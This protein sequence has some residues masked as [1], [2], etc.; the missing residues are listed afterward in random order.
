MK[1]AIVSLF[2]LTLPTLVSAQ[3]MEAESSVGPRYQYWT[4]LSFNLANDSVEDA[5]P[6]ENE[7]LPPVPD[8]EGELIYEVNYQVD[9]Y[10]ENL[11]WVRDYGV[12]DITFDSPEQVTI[13]TAHDTQ[14]CQSYLFDNVAGDVVSTD[15]TTGDNLV[16]EFEV[17]RN[18]QAA[19]GDPTGYLYM[20]HLSYWE[21]NRLWAGERRSARML[22]PGGGDFAPVDE[23]SF[24]H[25]RLQKSG[26]VT[27]IYV[28]GVEMARGEYTIYN[29]TPEFMFRLEQSS[30]TLRNFVFKAF[31][32]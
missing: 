1:S 17:R 24:D 9:K 6:E 12:C 28:N 26:N 2:F 25:Y 4:G 13:S 31:R 3:S 8:P 11:S 23:Y 22:L 10:G 16:L 20:Q 19:S 15:L 29:I 5:V 18:A 27:T 14:F 21:F 30:V 32:P 7:E